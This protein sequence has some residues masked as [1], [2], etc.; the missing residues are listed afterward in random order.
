MS[1]CATLENLAATRGEVETCKLRSSVLAK[2]GIII[3]SFYSCTEVHIQVC[4][5]F[6]DDEEDAY[7]LGRFCIM[8]SLGCQPFQSTYLSVMMTAVDIAEAC[9]SAGTYVPECK[10]RVW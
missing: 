1:R 8:T 6:K 4:D 7:R 10:A 2:S 5:D 3:P 9:A